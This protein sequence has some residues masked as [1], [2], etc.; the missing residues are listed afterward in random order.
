MKPGLR[1]RSATA[2]PVLDIAPFDPG[3]VKRKEEKNYGQKGRQD[4]SRTPVRRKADA[5]PGLHVGASVDA[6]AARKE[7]SSNFKEDRGTLALI[8]RKA[9]LL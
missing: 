7:K 9:A 8:G 3:Q 6:R 2:M 4:T 1:S 5:I